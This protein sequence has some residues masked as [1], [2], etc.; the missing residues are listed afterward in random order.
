ML[1]MTK[2][3]I[4]DVLMGIPKN[5]LIPEFTR[6]TTAAGKQLLEAIGRTVVK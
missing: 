1:F 5:D 2:E 6:L 3:H 4:K